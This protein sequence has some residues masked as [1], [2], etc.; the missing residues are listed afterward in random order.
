MSKNILNKICT[1]LKQQSDNILDK[2]IIKLKTYNAAYKKACED[3]FME[4]IA[5]TENGGTNETN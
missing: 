5:E 2:E 4:Y 3:V 1:E